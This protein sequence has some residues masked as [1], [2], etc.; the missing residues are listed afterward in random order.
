MANQYP[1]VYP[2]GFNG[3]ITDFNHA[4]ID[5]EGALRIYSGQVAVPSG[6]AA[7]SKIGIIPVRKGAKVA[8]NA[9]SLWFDALDSTT[10]ITFSA[11]I[12][13]NP[14]STQAEVP[15]QFIAAGA[16]TARAGGNAVLNQVE[17]GQYFVVQ[18]DGWLSV[19]T[20]AAAT[21][22]AGNINYNV[23]I[24]YDYGALQ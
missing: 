8:V 15:A 1:T 13:Y 16:T 23:A 19:T 9:S 21:N 3:T 20:A 18:D 24:A 11:G 4:K 12:T 17:S 2:A 5:R 7:G 14:S 22:T 6:T 10:T